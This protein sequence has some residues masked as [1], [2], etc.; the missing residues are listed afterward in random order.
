[1]EVQFG[2][3]AAEVALANEAAAAIHNAFDGRP[4]WELKTARAAIAVARSWIDLERIAFAQVILDAYKA[5]EWLPIAGAPQDG[6]PILLRMTGPREGAFMSGVWEDGA[7]K[8]FYGQV[9]YPVTQWMPIH[10]IAPRNQLS[11]D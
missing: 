9:E 5:G 2:S 6:T 7:W 10:G 8:V 11:G 4:G 3:A 1:M